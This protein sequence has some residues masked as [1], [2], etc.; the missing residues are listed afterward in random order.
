MATKSDPYVIVN[1]CPRGVDDGE[2]YKILLGKTV[3]KMKTLSPRWDQSFQ[4]SLP[5]REFNELAMLELTIMDYDKD[6]DDDLMGVVPVRINISRPSQ[7]TKWYGVPAT[8]A[9]GEEATGRIQCMLAFKSGSKTQEELELQNANISLAST[10]EARPEAAP[11]SSHQEEF[12][13]LKLVVKKAKD[14]TPMDRNFLGIKSSSDPYI[15]VRLCPHGPGG[16]DKK[17]FLGKTE[18]KPQTLNPEYNATFEKSLPLRHFDR[19]KAMI[20]LTILDADDNKDDDDLMG[21]IQ[22]PIPIGS[23]CNTIQWYDIPPDSGQGGR[24]TGK[25]M[26]ALTYNRIFDQIQKDPT[27]KTTSTL[28]GAAKNVLSKTKVVTSVALS[29]SKKV[30]RKGS[31]MSEVSSGSSDDSHSPPNPDGGG[32]DDNHNEDDN[33][34]DYPEEND[35]AEVLAAMQR[36]SNAPRKSGDRRRRPEDGAKRVSS[37]TSSSRRLRDENGGGIRKPSSRGLREEHGGDIRKPSSRALRDGN[38]IR[39]PTSRGLREEHGGDIRKPSSRGL[40]SSRAKIAE[41]GDAEGGEIRKGSS[42]GSRPSRPKSGESEHGPPLRRTKSSGGDE[43]P[44]STAHPRRAM[45]EEGKAVSSRRLASSRPSGGEDVE[46]KKSSSSSGRARP[47]RSSQEGRRQTRHPEG[48]GGE[49][50]K[51]S[52]SGKRSLKGDE[53]NGKSE[54]KPRSKTGTSSRRLKPSSEEGRPSRTRNPE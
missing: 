27:K 18:T 42:R 5:R 39:K 23:P 43:G 51:R 12:V 7:E 10:A 16:E 13:D 36:R 44:K 41:G 47:G 6:D 21:V 49:R 50:G 40:R 25:V 33:D 45:T 53:E 29:K 22:I 32:N 52:N 9:G 19:N 14:L 38:D 15:E 54:E 20:E 37:S 35:A 8:S 17:I 30:I 31:D 3:P 4:Y 26:C 28:K 46:G 48:E 34:E 1:L 24:V 11:R 2:N